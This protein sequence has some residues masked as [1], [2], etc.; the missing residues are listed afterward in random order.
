MFGGFQW[1]LGLALLVRASLA[2]IQAGRTP[3]VL[4]YLETMLA[5]HFQFDQGLLNRLG[6]SHN[7]PSLSQR[8]RTI[9]LLRAQIWA[10]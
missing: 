3:E 10:K 9:H 6:S 5:H 4:T 8:N 2:S 1:K 7:V